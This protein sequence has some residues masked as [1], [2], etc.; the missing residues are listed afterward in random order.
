MNEIDK[1][2]IKSELKLKV[3]PLGPMTGLSSYSTNG[4]YSSIP[5]MSPKVRKDCFGNVISKKFKRHK[6]SFADQVDNSKVF[7]EVNKVK[8]Y[9]L[10]NR[11]QE[12]EGKIF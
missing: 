8:S 6:I 3:E 5:I 11:S 4:S 10:F 1:N 9:R 12:E 7:I 2:K